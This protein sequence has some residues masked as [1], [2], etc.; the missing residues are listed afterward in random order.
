MDI[1]KKIDN[2]MASFA[3]WGYLDMKHAI[4]MYEEAGKSYDDLTEA[5][6]SYM[7]DTDTSI[8]KVDVCAVGMDALVQEARTEIEN[9]TGKDISNDEPYCRINVAGNYMA[10]SLDGEEE[11][12]KALA[13]LIKTMPEED[14]SA[15]V[16][17]ILE[18]VTR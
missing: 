2:F 8:D 11:D 18:E 4:E 9:A 14:R 3:P 16:K 17:W 1:D 6:Q 5:V 15:V 7:S 12:M 13:D 10:T